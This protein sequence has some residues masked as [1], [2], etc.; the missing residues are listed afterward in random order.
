MKSRQP[1]VLLVAVLGV[2]APLVSEAGETL[3]TSECITSNGVCSTIELVAYHFHNRVLST[4]EKGQRFDVH[5]VRFGLGDNQIVR[6]RFLVSHWGDI[7]DLRESNLLHKGVGQVEAVQGSRVIERVARKDADGLF[8]F[9]L[10]SQTYSR[11]EEGS[12]WLL[13]GLLSPDHQRSVSVSSW[14]DAISLHDRGGAT[15]T[16]ASGYGVALDPRSSELGKPPVLWL[17]NHRILTQQANGVLVVVGIDSSLQPLLKIAV[18]GSLF[19]SLALFRG[20]DGQVLYSLGDQTYEI[21]ADNA[22]CRRLEF[23]PVGNAIPVPG[24]TIFAFSAKSQRSPG[25]APFAKIAG[26]GI[27][28]PSATVMSRMKASQGSRLRG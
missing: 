6:G 1:L 22:T 8:Q 7:V 3:L 5:D 26:P 28:P 25:L 23:L 14:D 15:T 19:S 21:D 4:T 11:V 18:D 13:P 2:A 16:L 12:E 27:F 17:D 24:P 9:D 20:P 10:D